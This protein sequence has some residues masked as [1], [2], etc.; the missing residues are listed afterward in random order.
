[1]KFT[2]DLFTKSRQKGVALIIAIFTMVLISYL[3]VEIS[4]ESNVEYIVNA[5]AVSRLKAY[6]AAKS[7]VE[8][9]L[10]RIKLYNKAQEQFGGMLPPDRKKMLDMIWSFPFMWPPVIPDDALNMDKDQIKDIVKESKMDTQYQTT[11]ADEGSKIDINDLGSPSKALRD[12]TRKLLMGIFENRMT[13]D[14]DWARDNRELKFEEVINNIT[15][16]IDDDKQAINGGDERSRYT[17]LS[18]DLLPPNR[19][20][21]TVDEIRMVA[22]MTPEIFSMLKDR[23]TVYGMKAIN[24]NYASRDVLM[25]LDPSINNEV[26][27]EILKRRGSDELGGFYKDANDFWQYVNSKGGAVSQETQDKTPIVC[28]TVRN[29][30]IKSVG[31]YNNVTREIEAY[32][33]DPTA[34]AKTVADNLIKESASTGG[35]SGGNTGGN[36][37]GS[38]GGNSGGNTGGNNNQSKDP[39]PKG[40]P[41]IVYWMER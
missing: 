36:S 38:A 30:K 3:V 19:G 35:S 13:N 37:G 9:S 26:V 22:G 11:I 28:D 7:G 5:N 39:L 10:M 6:Y 27:S 21:R 12:V 41:R 25:S 34:T 29:F 33:F 24:P 16:W 17:K 2:R 15:D 8:L 14:E 4:Y 40:P 31:S 23:I 18:P 1:M 20:F 32:V